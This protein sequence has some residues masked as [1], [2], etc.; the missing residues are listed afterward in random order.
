MDVPGC[1]PQTGGRW[2]TA[3]AVQRPVAGSVP[4]WCRRAWAWARWSMAGAGLPVSPERG[5]R[6]ESSSASPAALVCPGPDGGAPSLGF[7]GVFRRLPTMARAVGG[8]ACTATPG[9]AGALAGS[10]RCVAQGLLVAFVA[11][12]ALLPEAQ[13]QT[14]I[15]MVG[16]GASS[17]SYSY[18]GTDSSASYRELAQRFTTGSNSDGYTLSTASIWFSSL[19]ASADV[20]NFVAAIYTNSSNRPGTLKYTLTNPSSN[21]ATNGKKDFSAPSNSTLDPSTKY[22]LVLMND[23]ATDGQNVNVA[24]T[25][26]GKDSDSLAGW[27]IENQRY[28]RSSMSG[29]WTSWPTELQIRISGYENATPCDALWCATMTVGANAL[30]WLG[31]DKDLYGALTPREFTYDGATVQVDQIYFDADYDDLTMEFVGSLAGSDY[32][33]VLGD[34]SFSLSDPGNSTFLEITTDDI[35]WTV[36]DTVTVKLF[37]G[38]EGGTVSDDA[39]LTSLEFSVTRGEDVELVTLT[40]AFASGT[41]EYTAAVGHRF[42]EASI[43]DI[44]RGDSGA[45]VVVTDEFA[46]HDLGSTGDSAEDLELAVGVNTITVTVT[47]ADGNTTETY[48]LVVTRAAP[49]PPPAHCETGDI[50]CATLTVAGLSDGEYGYSGA[51]G[52]LSHI[53]FEHDGTVY[54]VDALYNSDFGLRIEFSPTGETV[55]NTDDLFLDFDGTEFAFSDATFTSSYFAWADSGLLWS[56]ADT[57]EVRLFER[58]GTA[59]TGQPTISGTARVGETL[60]ADTS[61]IADADG[62]TSV[63]YSYQWIRVLDTVETEIPDATSST[64][65][66]VADDVGKTIRVK[67]TFTDDADNPETAI[68][69]AYPSSGTVEAD[70][71]PPSPESAAVAT[72]GTSVTVTFDE[73]LGHCGGIAADGGGRCLHGHRERC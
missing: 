27:S 5:E 57:V 8:R 22:W 39:T 4:A 9:T 38:L 34:L 59:A 18:L 31:F 3:S 33:L 30:G 23:N 45:S 13:A 28:Q 51:Q 6:R 67:V 69:D 36:G 53:D 12:L 48:T 29:S 61:G 58:S 64:Y 32:T 71:T 10:G 37:E 55:F 21:F 7:S 56:L 66:L 73:D 2:L 26:V 14:T 19:P 43:D 62:I 47:A 63:S 35:D 65:M 24:S 44:V 50:L 25:D 17:T 70:T 40:P 46:S 54:K 42:S 52:A 1:A 72:S 68:S 20:A 15:K 16:N 41:T 60:T 11:L 49:P